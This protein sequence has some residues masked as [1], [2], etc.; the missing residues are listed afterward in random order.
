M[1]Y[2][3]RQFRTKLTE[4]LDKA[5][6]GEV[7]EI[8]RQA[9]FGRGDAKLYTVQYKELIKDNGKQTKKSGGPS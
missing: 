3:I 1:R 9:K 7:V 4:A 5:D 2:N 6:G 8:E